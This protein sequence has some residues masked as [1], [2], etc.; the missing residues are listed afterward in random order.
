VGAVEQLAR[1]AATARTALHRGRAGG[2][3]EQLQA[4]RRY[5]GILARLAAAAGVE[6]PPLVDRSPAGRNRR[7]AEIERR[8]AA[9][10]G[11]ELRA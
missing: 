10:A 6:R 1:E 5:D 11:I 7:R 8:L 3:A 2:Q 4:L 9:D